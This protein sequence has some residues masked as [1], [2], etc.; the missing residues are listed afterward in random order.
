VKNLRAIIVGGGI[1]GLTAAIALRRAGHQAVVLE[2]AKSIDHVALGAGVHLWTNALQA[3]QAIDLAGEVAAAGTTVTAHRYLSWQGRPL[4]ALRVGEVSAELGAPTVGLSRPEL[5]RTLASALEDGVVRFNAEFI[6]FEQ[7][8]R[9]VVA[10]LADGGEEQGDILVGADG[11]KSVVR[12]QLHGWT[13]PHYSGL[14]AWR[15]ICDFTSPQVAVG[16]MCIYWGPGARILHYHV[17]GQR[18]YWLS[19]VKSPPRQRDPEGASKAAVSAHYLG[20]PRHVREMLAATEEAAILRTDIVDRDPLRRW[21]QDRVTLLGDA[22]H[23]MYPDMAQGAGQAIEDAVSLAAV[24]R[25]ATD[26]VTALRD[27]E[28]RRLRRANGFVKTSRIV[29]KMSLMQAP[30][31]CAVRNQVALRTVFAIQAAGKARKDLT[32]AL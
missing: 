1:G 21:G 13:E 10:R 3:L 14:T 20:W 17:S 31:M 16:E 5:H 2:R 15:A 25:D 4:G 11:I 7:N 24:L 28:Q 19:L 8:T 26:P 18:L 27:Y 9:R 6:G 23:P 32:P 12:Q 22:A 29:N 30:L